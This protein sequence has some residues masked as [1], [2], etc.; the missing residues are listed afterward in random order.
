MEAGSL[1]QSRS[2]DH[3]A[4]VRR[5]FDLG[6]ISLEARATQ[7]RQL[8]RRRLAWLRRTVYI[9]MGLQLRNARER[10]ACKATATRETI[11]P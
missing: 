9:C 5:C 3:A 11:G 1:A 6:V 7:L 8:V 2:F 10:E 4:C